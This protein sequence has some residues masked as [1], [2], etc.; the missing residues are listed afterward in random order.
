M[1]IHTENGIWG[2]GLIQAYDDFYKDTKVLS[3]NRH[4]AMIAIPLALYAMNLWLENFACKVPL[5][6]SAFIGA[7]LLILVLTYITVGIESIGSDRK[8]GGFRPA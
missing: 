7:G 5:H 6:W 8:P 2:I 1:D 3:V 4:A